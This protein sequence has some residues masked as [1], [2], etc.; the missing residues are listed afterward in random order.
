MFGVYLKGLDK[1]ENLISKEKLAEAMNEINVLEKGVQLS[2]TERLACMI[3][4]SQIMIKSRNYDKGLLLA[5]V[6]FRKSIELSEFSLVVDST[7][8]FFDSI[9]G[10]NM[11]EDLS[12]KEKKEY[13][14]MIIRSQD[15]VKTI[16]TMPVKE[17]KLRMTKLGDYRKKLAVTE[18]KVIE[19]KVKKAIPIGNVKGVGQKAEILKQAGIKT[20]KDL[21]KAK[22]EQLM[23]LK[24]IGEATAKKLINNAKE[25]IKG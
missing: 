1:V 7:L 15:I 25:A 16:D 6:A 18:K 14:K 17:K 8:S 13:S 20:A 24:G 5:K 10:L 22:I 11:L 19:K 3:L 12:T 23:K 4:S 9:H 2:E 21:A